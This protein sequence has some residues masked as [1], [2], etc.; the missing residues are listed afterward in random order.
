MHQKSKKITSTAVIS[1][2]VFSLFFVT[3]ALA[4]ADPALALNPTG[5]AP[6][7]IVA[8]TGSGFASGTYRVYF[9]KDD[10]ERYDLGEPYKS[11]T[12]G[13]PGT[14]TTTLAVPSVPSGTYDVRADVYP[15][16]PPAIASAPFTVKTILD[17][18]LDIESEISAIEAKLDDVTRWVSDF[19]LASAV[20][21]ITSVIDSA[22]SAI[23]TAISDSQGAI[24][25]KINYIDDK[26]GQGLKG[27]TIEAYVEIPNDD[28]TWHKVI[29]YDPPH[30]KKISLWI[31]M[32]SGYYL[33][34]GDEFNLRV[35]YYGNIYQK[36]ALE[37]DEVFHFH[38][39]QYL[40]RVWLAI[41]QLPV[42]PTPYPIE[43]W[44][45]RPQAGSG[46]WG[47]GPVDAFNIQ[48]I[49]EEA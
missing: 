14:F 20:S 18:L 37:S 34:D 44:I 15:Y 24:T 36:Q 16:A 45:Y 22:K 1:L 21:T 7:T 32:A 48:L 31:A 4:L 26:L 17:E 8:I 43:I 35:S 40:H 49:I 5:G 33:D 38:G 28:L 13:A 12:V 2:F 11:V 42:A 47:K 29:A 46:D 27:E 30:P 9:D 23:L 6:G 41:D 25:A 3:V 19:D 10:D 39:P